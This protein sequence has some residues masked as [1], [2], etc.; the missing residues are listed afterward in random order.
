MT[1]L[2]I[3][4][5]C[6]ASAGSVHA[7]PSSN[8]VHPASAVL[9]ANPNPSASDPPA[10]ND[11]EQ[12][13]ETFTQSF[14][15]LAY[16]VTAVAQSDSDGYGPGYLLN[17]VTDTGYWYQIG[18]SYD[19][20]YQNGGYV[21][22]FEVNYEV[23]DSSGNSIFPSSGGGGL[24][25]SGAVSNGD[26]VLLNLYF[27][28]GNVV[29]SAFDWNTGASASETY[30]AQGSEFIGLRNN[31]NSNGFFTGLMTEWYHVNAYYGG[32]AGV[33]YSNPKFALT[34]SYLWAD[35]YVAPCCSNVVFSTTSEFVSFASPLQIQTYSSNG[36]ES[37]A[38]AYE[39]T[40]GTPSTETLTASFSILGGGFGY[41]PPTLTYVYNNLQHTVTLTAAPQTYAVDPGSLWSV[42]E[43]LAGGSTNERWE[44]GTFANG[45][46]SGSMTENFVYY[47]QYLVSF[48]YT[49]KADGTGVTPPSGSA[50][51]IQYTQFGAATSTGVNSQVWADAESSYDY[52]NPLVASSNDRW[53]TS[54][55]NQTIDA[56][57]SISVTYYHQY[58][59]TVSYSV[60][61][62]GTPSFPFLNGTQFGSPVS[63]MVGTQPS[64]IWLDS[65]T[66]WRVSESLGGS[67]PQERWQTNSTMPISATGAFTYS[68]T[69]Y[70]QYSYNL[71]CSIVGGGTPVSSPI[72][73][74]EQFGHVDKGTFNSPSTLYFD[75]GSNWTISNP[76]LGSG[77]QERWI[78]TQANG[79]EVSA[80][81]T[82]SMSFRHQFYVRTYSGPA[83][84]GS[85]ENS[86]G[87][88]DSGTSASL[89]ASANTGWKSVGW[90]GTGS[91]SYTGSLNK[92][93]VQ[94]NGPIV[95]NA[96]FYPGLK[97]VVG[98][99]GGVSYSYDSQTGTVPPGGTA[100][101]F[102]PTGTQV[103]LTANPSNFLYQFK[104]W[105]PNSVGSSSRE[106]VTLDI[107]NSIQA[108]FA[109][110]LIT[111][112]A[113]LGV[114]IVAIL[115][116]DF[117]LR[118]RSK[119]KTHS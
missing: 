115:S 17:G 11:D 88:F 85:I 1:L 56:P 23:F 110:N 116:S 20:P 46:V 74:Y 111:I 63:Q 89:S 7:A 36:A 97:I 103:S 104:G 114:A 66:S 37:S 73:T 93:T 29:M 9:A 78:S 81:G 32:E 86:T 2:G 95:E 6:F 4:L 52:L 96:T 10:A 80:P 65:N 100:T 25:F 38:D 64:T 98:S 31:A 50:P 60:M 102:V 22:G 39:F 79:G 16:N 30:T 70:H 21:S 57:G 15:S 101:I 8:W 27:S 43:Y 76:L 68:I 105:A 108:S 67:T 5:L 14:T 44:L 26:S 45:L 117:A 12:I 33:T 54:S 83:S 49:T 42:S 35:E 72:L 59:V 77:N 24:T 119:P 69:Y 90:T 55:A 113:I 28:G 53:V 58:L 47:H 107:P 34:S 51:T 109:L 91:G 112:F 75:A 18:F 19:W 94:V 13:G 71:N 61:G 118:R 99:N 40:T 48:G 84:G 41:S 62:G 82:I 87:W 106:S 92:T 3:G